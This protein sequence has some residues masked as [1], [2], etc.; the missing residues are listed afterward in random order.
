MDWFGTQVFS[1]G[2]V[3]AVPIAVLAGLVSFFSPCILP[4]LPGYLSYVSGQ[5][6]H[7]LDD[8]PRPRVVLGAVLF[9]A[10]F[11]VTFLS[12]GLAFGAIGYRLIEHQVVVNTV[13]GLVMIVMGLAFAGRFA[14]LQRS[15]APRLVPRLG[16]AGAPVLGLLFG[17]GWTPCLGPTL[18][19]VLSLSL[20]EG[21][22]ARGSLLTAFYCLGLGMPFVAA[23]IAYRRTMRAAAWAKRHHRAIAIVSGGSMVLVGLLLV[24]GLWQELVNH[25]QGLISGYAVAV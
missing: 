16:L 17:V 24:S 19:A 21:S 20:T 10:G 12:Y 15:A 22:A 25:L 9:V 5:A 1:G 3:L 6:V 23:A 14:I 4:L 8:R 2:L 13:L 18:T 11:S 7:D